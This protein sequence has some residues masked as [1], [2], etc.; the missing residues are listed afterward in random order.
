MGNGRIVVTDA[1]LIANGDLLNENAD[2]FTDACMELLTSKADALVM[3]LTAAQRITSTHIGIIADIHF[4]AEDANKMLT[5][6]VTPDAYK[7]FTIT[8]TNE[9]LKLEVVDPS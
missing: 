5:V 8:N 4:R 9:V 2:E 6:K 3:D 7:V 1:L